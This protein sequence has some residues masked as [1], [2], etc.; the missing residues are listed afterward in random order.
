MTWYDDNKTSVDNIGGGNLDMG[1]LKI[2]MGRDMGVDMGTPYRRYWYPYH[3]QQWTA[4]PE[5]AAFNSAKW[6]HILSMWSYWST[7]KTGFERITTSWLVELRSFQRVRTCCTLW[8]S[9][10]CQTHPGLQPD[11][12][13]RPQTLHEGPFN[14]WSFPASHWFF[15]T[16]VLPD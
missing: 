14:T 5:A 7:S 12:A 11:G 16:T 13:C 8:A 4:H 10:C 3:T 6:Q 2:D 9:Q 15:T 1:R